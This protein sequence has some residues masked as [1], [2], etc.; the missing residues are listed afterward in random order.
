MQAYTSVDTTLRDNLAIEMSELI[1]DG[2]ILQE[3]GSTVGTDSQ[4]VLIVANGG[5]VGSGEGGIHLG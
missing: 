1:D 5:S 2:E 4:A 3:S